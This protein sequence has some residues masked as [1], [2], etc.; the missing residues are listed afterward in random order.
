MT[1]KNHTAVQQGQVLLTQNLRTITN[2]LIRK[3]PAL[4]KKVLI[5]N[6]ESTNNKLRENVQNST[7]TNERGP[8]ITGAAY[9]C[10]TESQMRQQNQIQAITN[11]IEQLNVVTSTRLDLKKSEES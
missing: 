2:P 7:H 9:Y 4:R 6:V 5:K 10:F 8:E 11:G 3:E 1:I